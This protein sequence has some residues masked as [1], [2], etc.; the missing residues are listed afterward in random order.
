MGLHSGEGVVP[1]LHLQAWEI[2]IQ[3]RQL[4]HLRGVGIAGNFPEGSGSNCHPLH[5][6]DPFQVDR[7]ERQARGF[8]ARIFKHPPP[9]KRAARKVFV[10][11]NRRPEH[12]E[13]LSKLRGIGEPPRNRGMP[14]FRLHLDEAELHGTVVFIVKL[15]ETPLVGSG[16]HC[17]KERVVRLLIGGVE[18]VELGRL[19]PGV[20]IGVDVGVD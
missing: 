19:R 16:D 4:G 2:R 17:F 20:P 13:V 12:C 1:L 7:L 14:P 8:V 18:A 5:G 10:L 9:L 11:R 6:G 15:L 3:L